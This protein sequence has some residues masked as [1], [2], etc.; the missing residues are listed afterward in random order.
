MPA[1]LPV[2]DFDL[3]VLI[4]NLLENV[5]EACQR[6]QAGNRHAELKMRVIGNILVLTLDNTFDGSCAYSGDR[7]L[8]SKRDYKEP[9]I[10]LAS[11]AAITDKY[12]GELRVKQKDNIFC[13]S[14]LLNGMGK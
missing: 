11:V 6:V 4:G 1:D 14:V 7:L 2:D 13:V 5:G 3:C 8:S 12:Q 10:G 9:G